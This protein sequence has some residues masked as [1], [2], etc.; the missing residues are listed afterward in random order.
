MMRRALEIFKRIRRWD[1]D[2]N[3]SCNGIDA[4]ALFCFVGGFNPFEKYESILM[5]SPGSGKKNSM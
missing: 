1:V 3:S 4:L 5:I 2:S